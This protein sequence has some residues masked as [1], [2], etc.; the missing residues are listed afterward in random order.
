LVDLV[1][2]VKLQ[3][4]LQPGRHYAVVLYKINYLEKLRLSG[5]CRESSVK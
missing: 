5:C 3:Q 1:L 4:G 2:L